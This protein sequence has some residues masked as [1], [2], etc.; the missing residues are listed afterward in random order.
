[1]TNDDMN[2]KKNDKRLRRIARTRAKITGTAERPRLT[3]RRSLV[4]VYA[5]VIDDVAR[6]TLAA[7]SDADLEP[8]DVKGKKKTDVSLAVGKL[9][10]ERAKAK[11]VT[12]V[13]FD[14][15]DKQYHGRVKAVADGAREGGLE[16]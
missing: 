15:R 16:F 13:V 8:T 5:Q 6:K 2:T 3:V 9:I 12:R 11:G 14:R 10:A 4:H 7:A 1:M